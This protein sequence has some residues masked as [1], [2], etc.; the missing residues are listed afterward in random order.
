MT[1]EPFLD[2]KSQKEIPHWNAQHGLPFPQ[3]S[4]GFILR[5]T[6]EMMAF[7]ASLA[8]VVC[9]PRV[10]ALC[11]D[12][13]AGKT[14]MAKGMISALTG[15]VLSEVTSPTFQYVQFYRIRE[16]LVA[17]FD[18]WRLRGVDEFVELGLEEYL[19]NSMAIVEWPERIYG[20]LPK[21]TIWVKTSII[22]NGRLVTIY[23]EISFNNVRP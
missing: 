5:D 7:G 17:H 20:L 3:S 6:E 19:S 9:P 14:T 21:N 22:E 15:I 16:L 11:G 1:Q 8:S 13:G 12:L 2:L 23:P 18:V 10:V 4:R